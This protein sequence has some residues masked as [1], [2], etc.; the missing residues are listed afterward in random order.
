MNKFIKCKF[1]GCPKSKQDTS[2]KKKS[3][4]SGKLKKAERKYCKEHW[5]I[6]KQEPKW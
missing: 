4:M 5:Y 2:N 1:E 3:S 6:Q